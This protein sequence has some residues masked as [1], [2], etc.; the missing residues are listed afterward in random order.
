MNTLDSDEIFRNFKPIHPFFFL[1]AK[2]KKSLFLQLILE[3]I[4]SLYEAVLKK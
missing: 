4:W 3:N 2:G 1:Q